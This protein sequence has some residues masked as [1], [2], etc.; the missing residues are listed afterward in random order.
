MSR[1]RNLAIGLAF[2]ALATVVAFVREVRALE[3]LAAR[4]GN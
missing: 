4:R 3:R 2:G 1:A